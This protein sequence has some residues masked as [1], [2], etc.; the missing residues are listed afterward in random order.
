MGTKADVRVEVRADEDER[1]EGSRST[2]ARM[3]RAQSRIVAER[4]M[5]RRAEEA[6]EKACACE[7][8]VSSS[9]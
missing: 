4:G 9:I 2:K 6:F 7:D 3:A 5:A 8:G 1:N